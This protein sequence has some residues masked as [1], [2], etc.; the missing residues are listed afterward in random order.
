MGTFLLEFP[1]QTP[2]IEDGVPRFTCPMD[3]RSIPLSWDFPYVFSPKTLC[4]C[5]NHFATKTSPLYPKVP[6]T[7]PQSPHLFFCTL[8]PTF[9][10]VELAAIVHFVAFP[11]RR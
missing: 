8:P 2:Y 9:C 3:R 10:T 6:T 11:S 5:P 1:T 4:L 7:M